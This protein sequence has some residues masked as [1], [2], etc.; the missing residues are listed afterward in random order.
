MPIPD[1]QQVAWEDKQ[2]NLAESQAFFYK[3]IRA[4]CG[5]GM[6]LFELVESTGEAVNRI[7]GRI[8]E[9]RKQGLIK[10]S[11]ARRENPDSGKR[12]IVWIAT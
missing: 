9:L 7:S 5:A 1:T 4:R 8:T 3:I 12:G 10:D 2:K 11:G 6:T